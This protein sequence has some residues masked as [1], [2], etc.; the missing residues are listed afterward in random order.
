VSADHERTLLHFQRAFAENPSAA[1]RDW[2]RLQEEL[3][4]RED[5]AELSRALADDFWSLAPTLTL[6]SEEDRARF[7]HNA[8]VFFG[9][10]GPA[11]N[12]SRAREAFSIALDH[13]SEHED[14]GWHARIL[15]NFATSLS[16]L[17]LT[18]ADLAE[19][20]ALFKRAL[21]WRTAER[22]IARGV[23][24]HNLGIALRRLARVD[25]PRSTEHLEHSAACLEEAS[26][27]R[28][29][30]GLAEGRALS[31]FGITQES[32][33]RSEAAEKCFRLAADLFDRLEKHDSA[34]IARERAA[35]AA[36]D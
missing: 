11:A 35:A 7:F 8:A 12:L 28:A 4:D 36:E 27:F 2:F 25:P 5:D 20:V 18:A 26:E 29:R 9:T 22:E 1:Y 33:K 16:N 34:A 32:L 19:S 23:S 30:H 3:R 10:P 24:L 31:L 14:G 15:H 17:G 13:F 6:P 21:A